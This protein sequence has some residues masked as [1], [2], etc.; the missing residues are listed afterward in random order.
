[1][2][3]YTQWLSDILGRFETASNTIERGPQII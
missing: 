2:M 3:R 1:M